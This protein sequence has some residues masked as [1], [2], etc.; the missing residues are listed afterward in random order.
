MTNKDNE[1]ILCKGIKLDRNYENVL[2]Y[3][4][5]DMVS[6]CRNNAIYQ[7]DEYNFI[8]KA[9]NRIVVSHPYSS[10]MYANYVAFKNPRFGNKWIFAWVTDVRLINVGSTEIT[11]DVDVWSTWYSN[12]NIGKGFIEREHVGDDTFGKH[13]V[14]ENIDTGEMVVNNINYF[15]EYANDWWVVA[16]VSKLPSE[17]YSDVLSNSGIPTRCYNGVYSGLTYIAFK[18]YDDATKFLLVM[19]GQ[20]IAD[21]VYDVFIVP[22]S[23]VVIENNQFSSKS[24]TGSINVGEASFS[25][26]FTINY[27]IIPNTTTAQAMANSYTVYIN[28]TLDGYTPKNNKMF[29]GEFNYM[30]LC[31]NAGATAKYNY[32]DFYNSTPIFNLIGAVCPG[33]SI[34]LVPNSYKNYEESETTDNNLNPYGLTAG[35]YPVCSWSSDSYTNWLTQQS[36][37]IGV[38]AASSLTSTLIAGAINPVAGAVS[39]LT[40]GLGLVSDAIKRDKQ[41]EYAPV[42]AKGNLNAGDVTFSMGMNQFVLYQMS[43]RNEYAKICD[44]Y[45]SRYGY[46]VNEVKQ[47]NLKTRT[48]FNFIKV[49]GMDDLV[50]GNIPA[51]DLEKINSIFRKGVTIFHN[52]SN[53]G[54]YTIS[55]PIR[56]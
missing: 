40:T 56:T 28:S 2:S 43:C 32:E 1:I 37:N 29:T 53:I 26:T 42:Q 25:I 4:E 38:D 13:T 49:G 16:G 31:N 21:N 35:K 9:N 17:I 8:E 51:S 34:R 15:D 11:F 44:N 3:S 24:C 10:A 20:G 6:L 7:A 52:Y 47:P 48:Q 45:L 18:T 12:F 30:L 54:N 23:L 36:V 14:P 50:H 27:K 39:G 33:C 19:D 22:K 46:K 41:R 55:N 5:S